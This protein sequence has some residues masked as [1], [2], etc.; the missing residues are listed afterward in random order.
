VY[1]LVWGAGPVQV[2]VGAVIAVPPVE[3]LGLWWPF[4]LVALGYV[5]LLAADRLE[6]PK[7]APADRRR[8]HLLDW[9]LKP[10]AVLALVHMGWAAATDCG[11]EWQALARAAAPPPRPAS[12]RDGEVAPPAVG[13]PS[14][15]AFLGAALD[16]VARVVRAGLVF[17]ARV[18]VGTPLWLP[19]AAG[20]V[21]W[22]RQ[23][24]ERR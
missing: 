18:W 11:P 20:C 1:A 14:P 15:G 2:G 22:L 12:A 5:V 21:A 3:R 9:Y 10:L 23:P 17:V 24:A 16:L 8:R 19:A 13:P 7:E 6:R 4:Y